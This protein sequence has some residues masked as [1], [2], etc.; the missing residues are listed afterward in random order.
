MDG[1]LQHRGLCGRCKSS[2]ALGDSIAHGTPLRPG[3]NDAIRSVRR[4]Y[5]SIA[6][7]ACQVGTVDRSLRRAASAL[8]LPSKTILSFSESHY[9]SCRVAKAI[10]KTVAIRGEARHLTHN[11]LH[12]D[13]FDGD[14][15][16]Y[17]N[18]NPATG[19]GREAVLVP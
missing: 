12:L 8:P 6:R 11:V 2:R 13:W 16:C 3:H 10:L 5:P 14:V 18:V 7:D 9:D 1:W 15:A 19:S 17:C 4:D